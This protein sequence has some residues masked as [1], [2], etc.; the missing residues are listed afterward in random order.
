MV[1]IGLQP[2]R[3]FLAIAAQMNGKILNYSLIAREIGIDSVTV[4]NYFE[5]LQYTMLGYFLPSYNRSIRKAQRQ[6]PKF[7]FIDTGKK[8]AL[9]KTLSVELLPQTYAW[10]EAFESFFLSEIVKEISYHRLEWSI[11]YLR[12]KYDQEIHLIIERP[13]KNTVLIQIKS[14]AKVREIDAKTLETLGSDV[15]PKAEKWIVSLDPLSQ[16]FG[17]TKALHW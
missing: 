6:S 13:E 16:N 15:D 5:I 7:Y 17:T 4:S 12:T 9:D 2:F 8:R 11:S 10:E 1:L 14:K 3:K